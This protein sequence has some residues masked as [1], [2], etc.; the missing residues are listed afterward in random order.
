MGSAIYYAFSP[1][2]FYGGVVLILIPSIVGVS[3]ILKPLLNSHLWHILE[4][5]TLFAYLLQY[6]VVI[7]F[8]SSRDQNTIL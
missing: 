3:T 1:I 8:F 4:E 6:L 2:L 7:W 5:L